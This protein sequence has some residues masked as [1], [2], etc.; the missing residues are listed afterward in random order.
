M[1]RRPINRA[2]L[3]VEPIGRAE[4]V[5]SGKYVTAPPNADMVDKFSFCS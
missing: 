3:Q 5:R 4:A 1:E 2:A